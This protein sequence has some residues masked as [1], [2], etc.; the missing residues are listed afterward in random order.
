MKQAKKIISDLCAIGERQLVGEK[1][2]RKIIEDFLNG[3]HISFS[4]QEYLTEIPKYTSWGLKVD[5]K[6]VEAEPCGY[7]SGKIITNATLLSSLISSQKN[8]YDAN[9]NFNPSADRISRSNHYFA[10]ALAIHR[11]DVGRVATAQKVDGFVSVQKSKHQS[12]NI[13]VGNL[14]NPKYI[15]FSHYDSVSTGAVDNA[16]GTAL[17]LEYILEN[18]KSLEEN[19]FAL[20]GNEELSYDEPIYWGHGYRVFEQEYGKLLKNAKGILVLD[21]F[22]H[23]KPEI[24]T[25]LSIVTLGFPIKKIKMYLPKIKMVA[26]SLNDLMR[27]YHASNDVPKNIDPKYFDHT[28]TLLHKLLR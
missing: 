5:G 14:K 21:S 23:S 24:I 11:K 10:P 17:S 15:V 25:D 2:A 28:K 26:G 22:G 7:V 3:H 27:F 16:S 19:L 1:T 9:I 8:L 13:L 6:I 4:A 18:P 20:C 12:A